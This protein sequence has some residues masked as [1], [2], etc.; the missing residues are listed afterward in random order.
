MDSPYKDVEVRGDKIENKVYCG[1]CGWPQ[2][3]STKKFC[4]DCEQDEFIRNYLSGK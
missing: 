1:Y 3:D 4:N 2:E